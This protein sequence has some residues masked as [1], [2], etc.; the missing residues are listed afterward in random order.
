MPSGLSVVAEGK[1]WLPGVSGV[2]VWSV[3][4]LVGL[5]VSDLLLGS[6]LG[7]LLCVSGGHGDLSCPDLGLKLGIDLVLGLLVNDLYVS[8]SGL[9]AVFDVGVLVVSWLVTVLDGNSG[10]GSDKSGSK[11]HLEVRKRVIVLYY[12]S[13][14]SSAYI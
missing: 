2:D 5:G 6:V 1:S 9:S 12:N 8:E 14:K 10:D 3:L 4:D 13:E 7:D 11:F